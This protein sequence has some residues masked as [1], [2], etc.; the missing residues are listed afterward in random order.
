MGKK[1]A[2]LKKWKTKESHCCYHSKVCTQVV[3]TTCL[4][5]ILISH[6]FH[7]ILF[8]KGVSNKGIPKA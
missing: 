7:T 8:E 4:F 1:G 5:E 6:Y 2:T 3:S